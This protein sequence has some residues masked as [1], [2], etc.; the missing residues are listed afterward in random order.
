MEQDRDAVGGA[1]DIDL[2][3]LRAERLGDRHGGQRVLATDS[4][5]T[6]VGDEAGRT[7]AVPPGRFPHC[8]RDRC[9]RR[10]RDRCL[11]RRHPRIVADRGEPEVTS[12]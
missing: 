12:S 5:R 4:R 1:P 2:D 3:E 8:L 7:H 10:R 6:A 9:L 11:R